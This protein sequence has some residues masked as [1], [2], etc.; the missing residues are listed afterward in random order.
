M[1]KFFFRTKFQQLRDSLTPTQVEDYSIAIANQLLELPIWDATY[2]HLFLSILEKKEVDTSH[3]LAILH[4]KDKEVVVSKSNNDSTLTNFLLT[5]N[6]I[7][8]KNKWNIPEPQNGIEVPNKTIDVV[9]VPLLA[10]DKLGNRIGYGKGY[11]DIFLKDCRP[12]VIKIGLTF[13]D[14]I[15]EKISA[16]KHDI[17]LDWIV[18]PKQGYQF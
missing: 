12:D 14:P 5:D 11:Y 13:F 10:Y 6:T 4:G 7:L 15:S 1:D 16:E 2:F 17:P 18:S 3:I 9:F 8:K